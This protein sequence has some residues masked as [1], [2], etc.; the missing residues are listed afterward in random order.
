MAHKTQRNQKDLAEVPS[1]AKLGFLRSYGSSSRD[2]VLT[3]FV[4]CRLEPSD[5]SI[6]S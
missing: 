3:S 1:S 5:S 2:L 4:L 6:S